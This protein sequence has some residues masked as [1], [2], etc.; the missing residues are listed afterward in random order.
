[1]KEK[2][3]EMVDWGTLFLT[4]VVEVLLYGFLLLER[5]GRAAR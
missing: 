4:C 3:D 2:G 5:L 1:M